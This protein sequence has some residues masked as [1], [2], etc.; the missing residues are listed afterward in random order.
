MNADGR[1]NR[2]EQ[3]VL[4]AL[5]AGPKRTAQLLEA[6]GLRTSRVAAASRGLRDAGLVEFA[7][8]AY[9]LAGGAS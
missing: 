6:T 7:D 4:D 5:R 1:P 2:E 9:R 8:G 3:K